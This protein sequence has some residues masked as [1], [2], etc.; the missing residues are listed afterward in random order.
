MS[1]AKTSRK[2]ELERDKFEFWTSIGTRKLYNGVTG[3]FRNSF[4][5]LFIGVL[6][7]IL[8]ER[9]FAEIHKP[10]T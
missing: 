5:P 2:H 10:R 8:N 4:A 7:F 3:S 6:F 1:R 9:A